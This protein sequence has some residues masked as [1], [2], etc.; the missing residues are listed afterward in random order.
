MTYTGLIKNGM[1]VFDKKVSLVEGTPV[2]VEAV[3]QPYDIEAERERLRKAFA[4]VEQW[5][6]ESPEYNER[7]ADLLAVELAKDRGLK[8][9][10]P[11]LI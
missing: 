6:N 1:V 8:L 9:R 10:Q 11:D 5:D 7:V 2:R 3:Q 4:L